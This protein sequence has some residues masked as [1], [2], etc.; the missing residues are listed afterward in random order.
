MI[1][2]TE[3]VTLLSIKAQLDR[4]ESMLSQGKMH[5]AAAA[6]RSIVS[7][8][9]PIRNNGLS[10]LPLPKCAIPFTGF[11]MEGYC[12][13]LEYNSGLYTQCRSPLKREDDTYCNACQI[14]CNG[15]ENDKPTYG[16]M[17]DRLAVDL[18]NFVA[19]DGRV[20]VPY[21][22][23][24]RLQMKRN[25]MTKDEFEQAVREDAGKYGIENIPSFYFEFPED[26]ERKGRPKSEK[27]AKPAK[28]VAAK[29]GRPKKEA[30]SVNLTG[31]EEEVD[32]FESLVACANVESDD[33]SD[34]EGQEV[35]LVPKQNKKEQERQEREAKKEQERQE[36]EAKKQQELEAKK[37]QELEAKNA[38]ASK[39]QAEPVAETT[40]PAQ[41]E[42]PDKVKTFKH[43]GTKY[44][45][46]TKTGV[47][48]N[49]EQEVV[50]KWNEETQDIIFNPASSDSEEEEEE[51]YAESEVEEE[52]E[53]E[54]E[55]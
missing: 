53:E 17:E 27:A 35:A 21:W 55:E 26:A 48:Y 25:N 28:E 24:M 52:E 50:G 1:A 40:A 13:G 14:E 47:V 2:N 23:I 16:C 5:K 45:K 49:M 18:M 7:R 34:N 9:K 54:E 42:E 41:A 22:K 32:L 6:V 10:K 46:S 8:D 39:K 36:R 12:K 33:E 43:K 15:N 29:K 19:P 44:L 4:I 20:V 51:N 38:K 11:C 31:G 3:E 30:K 37:Q